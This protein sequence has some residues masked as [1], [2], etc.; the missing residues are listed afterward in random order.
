MNHLL[1]GDQ[2]SKKAVPWA[3][4]PSWCCYSVSYRFL[5][6]EDD[7]TKIE[8]RKSKMVA[9][10]D[11]CSLKCKI[12]YFSKILFAFVLYQHRLKILEETFF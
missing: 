10:N 6:V 8:P 4:G 11:F 5:G 2:V 7:E 9:K 3:V 1:V 12:K